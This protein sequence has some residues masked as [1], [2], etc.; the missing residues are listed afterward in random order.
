[1]FVAIILHTPLVTEY[2]FNGSNTMDSKLLYQ[3][4]QEY[5]FYYTQRKIYTASKYQSRMSVEIYWWVSLEFVDTFQPFSQC[6]PRT[7]HGLDLVFW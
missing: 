6:I 3:L 1:M 4:P 2:E 5:C 7:M